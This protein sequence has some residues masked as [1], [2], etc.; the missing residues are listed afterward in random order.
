[1]TGIPL[2]DMLDYLPPLRGKLTPNNN[3]GSRTWFRAGGNAEL[4]FQPLDQ[5]DLANFLQQRPPEVK[6]NIIG[7]GSNILVR[8]GGIPG[9]TIKLR[10]GFADVSLQQDGEV[11]IVHAGSAA[12]DSTVAKVAA[13]NNLSGLEFLSGVPGTIGGALKM[14]AG[15][16]GREMVDVVLWATALDEDGIERKLS[17]DE[18]GFNYRHCSL[19]SNWV[20]I[21][22]ALKT[23]KGDSKNISKLMNHISTSRQR[24]Q[25]T[26]ERTSGSTFKNPQGR[27]AWELIDAA[28]C[29]GLMIG[30]A[31]ISE[32]H[33]NFLINTRKAT[34]TDLEDLG[35]Q[36]RK[37][38]KDNS[39]ILLEWEIQRIGDRKENT[40]IRMGHD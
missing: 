19:P 38:V 24:D 5:I 11:V 29:R 33:C 23:T 27:K 26:Q 1:M 14:N 8:D 10:R 40:T 37:R 3:I 2:K 17:L 13:N 25:P 7:V 32:H 16:Y 30:D 9:I 6:I 12:L 22:V 31:K 4:L 39:G 36:V 28:G 20:F 18:L 21:S 35:E 15:A 34:A